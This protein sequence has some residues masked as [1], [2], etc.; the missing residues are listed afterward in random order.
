MKKHN[1]AERYTYQM[2]IS[3]KSINLSYIYL[4]SNIHQQIYM[5]SSLLAKYA[6]RAKG[7]N[8]SATRDKGSINAHVRRRRWI[9]GQRH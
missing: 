5:W 8:A 9:G 2:N 3:S 1:I 4:E 7:I 6:T